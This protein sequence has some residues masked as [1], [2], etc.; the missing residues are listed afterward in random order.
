MNMAEIFISRCKAAGI[1]LIFLL[2]AIF[3]VLYRNDRL[4]KGIVLGILIFAFVG[5]TAEIF[6]MQNNKTRQNEVKLL[7][8]G[9][10]NMDVKKKNLFEST[11]IGAISARNRIIRAAIADRAH[12]D[13]TQEVIENYRKLAAGGV[14]VII[15]G[16][17]TVEKREL[18]IPTLAFHD[19]K[20][21]SQ[22]KPL[23]DAVHTEGGKIVLQIASVGS[24]VIGGNYEGVPIY[25]PSAVEH[26]YSKIIPKEMTV[27]EIKQVQKN[28]ADAALRAKKAGYDGVE[29]HGAHNFLLSL[30][31]SP[32]YNKRADNY[33]GS[34]ENRSRM[35]LE[36]V[37]AARQAV[38]SDYPLWVK[39]N[40]E[41]HF[42]GGITQEDFLYQCR[43]LEK[44]GV[45]AIE[46]SGNWS[47]VASKE[48]ALYL[49]ESIKAAETVSTDI[50]ATGGYRKIAQM[51]EILDTTGIDAFG[52]ARPFMKSPNMNDV[53]E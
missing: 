3:F 28:F 4:M 34:V 35:L 5:H 32:Y 7:K 48:G 10:N 46:I 41:E 6:S 45:N 22:H 8:S 19:D 49:K 42:D 11:T 29:I 14:G 17:V 16:F 51:Q 39:I 9:D 50:I 12:G 2:A 44:L 13:V 33:G 20:Y 47:M 53:L 18:F 1:N 30:F 40:S 23:I 38:G 21:I 25:A 43:E 24:F 27:E 37:S 26:M 31:S 36:T 15:T 52:I